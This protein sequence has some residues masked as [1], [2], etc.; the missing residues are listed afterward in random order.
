VWLGERTWAAN[1]RRGGRIPHAQAAHDQGGWGQGGESPTPQPSST[2]SLGNVVVPAGG[3]LRRSGAGRGEASSEQPTWWPDDSSHLTSGGMAPLAPRVR[4]S[5][6][7]FIERYST[8]N[9]ALTPSSAPSAARSGPSLFP[10][11][12]PPTAG[13]WEAE[14][15]YWRSE[16][17]RRIFCDSTYT[18]R[19]SLSETGTGRA[20]AGST[21]Q[22]SHRPLV[23]VSNE[24]EAGGEARRWEAPGRR[25]LA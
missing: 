9:A 18:G 14:G 17:A 1:A 19:Y 13:Q 16:L 5:P 24:A 4:L 10:P 11:T 12:P 2:Q 23:S 6:A 3:I 15:L 25:A 7:S 22:T 20:Q 8:M 21:T